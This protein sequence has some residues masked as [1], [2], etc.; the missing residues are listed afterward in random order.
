M[1][2]L[3][4]D[5]TAADASK[6]FVESL[7]KTGFAVLKNHPISTSMIKKV[8]KDWGEFFASEDKHHYLFD[9]HD[10]DGFFP[11]EVSE[12]AKGFD[13]KDIKEY[14]HYYPWA[15]QPACIGP[16]TLQLFNE[17]SRL[18]GELLGWIEQET[19]EEIRAKFSI[20]LSE[21]I[22]SCPRTL[23]RIL[24]YPPLTGNE[25]P[26]AVR[27]AEHS[28]INLI[29]LLPAATDSGLQVKDKSGKWHDVSCDFGTIVVNIADMLQECSDHYFPSTPH[30][31]I[32]PKG[33]ACFR[34]RL[35][36]P[37]FLHARPEV[38]L[39]ERYLVGEYWKERLMEIGVL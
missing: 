25:Q 31:V 35:S 16:E 39:S 33:D 20:P 2:I 32:N 5:L 12:V 8:Y 13:I 37:L 6:N 19:P 11:M 26:G 1:D 3:T 22:T 34:S 23:L 18:A 28:D 7:R 15:R 10:H 9:E 17:M 21:M 38:R 29:T 27:A 30:R 4:V 36:L 24:H 14:Y